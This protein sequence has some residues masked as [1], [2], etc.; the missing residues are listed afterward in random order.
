MRDPRV[1]VA[2]SKYYF[3]KDNIP[4]AT[5]NAFRHS[6]CIKT[7]LAPR[8]ASRAFTQLSA[9][10][11]DDLIEYA[12]GNRSAA[13]DVSL[14]LVEHANGNP[15]MRD[16]YLIHAILLG[17][18]SS[19]QALKGLLK[20]H[21]GSRNGIEEPSEIV[22]GTTV[23]LLENGT[24]VERVLSFHENASVLPYDEGCIALFSNTTPNHPRHSRSVENNMT[25]KM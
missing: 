4:E 8:C 21:V 19:D 16:S 20:Y 10:V 25:A 7:R 5:H 9:T 14:A 11:P 23:F 17:E 3:A 24:G 1:Y 6:A 2:I 15:T 18:P 13:M 22:P 12:L